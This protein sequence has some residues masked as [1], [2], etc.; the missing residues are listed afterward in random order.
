M[1]GAAYGG[2][3][4]PDCITDALTTARAVLAALRQS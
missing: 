2:V 3:G 4:I 1:T